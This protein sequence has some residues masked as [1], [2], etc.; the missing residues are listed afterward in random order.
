MKRAIRFLVNLV[1]HRSISSARW[2]D[3]YEN[4]K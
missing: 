2:L 4:T 1:R 3:Q